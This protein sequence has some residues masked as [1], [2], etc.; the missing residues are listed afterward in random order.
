MKRVFVFILVTLIVK[1]F[2]SQTMQ[3]YIILGND[4][5][6]HKNFAN[7]VESYQKILD[8]GLESPKL[9]FNLGNAYYKLKNY[10]KAV[11]YYEKAHKLDPSDEKVNFNLELV[12]TK[13]Q[14]KIETLPQPFYRRWFMRMNAITSTDSW[15]FSGIIFL[16]L[17]TFFV[18]VFLVA[19]Q[20]KWRKAAFIVGLLCVFFSTLSFVHASVQYNNSEA[21]SNAIILYPVVDVCSSPDAGSQHIFVIHEGTKVTITDKVGNWLNV[22]I[23]NGS[24]GW[25]PE[26]VLERI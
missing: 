16:F 9:Y 17:L 6:N 14:D 25:V 19:N 24:D 26:D 20:V 13:I 11:L 18:A 10:P 12:N 3:E 21:A 5:Y 4:Q 15:A 22:R 2:F 7:A 1:V 8:K 23:A